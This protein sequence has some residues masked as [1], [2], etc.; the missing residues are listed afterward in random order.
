MRKKPVRLAKKEKIPLW[1]KEY[2]LFL[3]IPIELILMIIIVGC[4][5]FLIL[6]MIGSCTDSGQVYNRPWA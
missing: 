5:F 2:K 1:D 3:G 4:I 6:M